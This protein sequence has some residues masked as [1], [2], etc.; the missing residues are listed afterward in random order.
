[1]QDAEQVG[2]T[3]GG[4]GPSPSPGKDLVVSGWPPHFVTVSH[5]RLDVLA[6]RGL[7][8]FLL[9]GQDFD[10]LDGGPMAELCLRLPSC[11]LSLGYNPVDFWRKRKPRGGQMELEVHLSVEQKQS[12]EE[13]TIKAKK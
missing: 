10:G 6:T 9:G 3:P 7:S 11:K 5:H 2:R 12:Q 1:M 4:A 8:R 13:K